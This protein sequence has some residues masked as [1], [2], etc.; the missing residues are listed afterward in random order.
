N[1]TLFLDIKS[2]T[3]GAGQKLKYESTTSGGYRNLKIYIPDAI[4]ASR[5]VEIDYIVRNGIR[6]FEGHDEFY[7]NITGNDW[8]VPIDHVAAEVFLPATA[9]DP[10]RA[11]AFTGAYG[12]FQRDATT[13]IKDADV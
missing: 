3:D 6:Y 1:Y 9:A 7:W 12:S 5:T 8:P 4:D 11:Q 13:E 10:L 2:V